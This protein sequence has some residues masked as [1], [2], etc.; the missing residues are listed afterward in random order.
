[1]T[2]QPQMIAMLFV[3]T[4]LLVGLLVWRHRA[5]KAETQLSVLPKPVEPY[6]VTETDLDEIF[7]SLDDTGGFLIKSSELQYWIDEHVKRDRAARQ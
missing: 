5:L 7:A 3:Q 1:M 6:H 4:V 2:P